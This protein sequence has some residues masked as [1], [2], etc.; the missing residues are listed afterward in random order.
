VYHIV[1]HQKDQKITRGGASPQ[2]KK[3]FSN[4]FSLYSPLY[5]QR[6]SILYTLG[7]KMEL[8]R[9]GLEDDQVSQVHIAVHISHQLQTAGAFKNCAFVLQDAMVA[10]YIISIRVT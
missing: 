3:L 1:A 5:G 6:G 2:F 10:C 8:K 4:G 9:R 7:L